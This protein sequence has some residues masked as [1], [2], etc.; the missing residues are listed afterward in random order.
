VDRL[1]ETSN[2]LALAAQWRLQAEQAEQP[3]HRDY[4]LQQA[5]RFERILQRSLEVPA[6]MEGQAEHRM[7]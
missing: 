6:V 7:S 5:L 1:Y 3:A 4:C 2:L